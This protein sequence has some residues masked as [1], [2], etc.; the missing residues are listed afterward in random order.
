[1]LF[2]TALEQR[3]IVVSITQ[4]WPIAYSIFFAYKL[5]K[6]SK[7]PVTISLSSFFITQSI[8][9]LMLIV[10]IFTVNTSVS[11]P[12]YILGYYLYFFSFA[13]LIIFSWIILNVDKKDS[14]KSNFV[15]IIFYS[16]TCGCIIGVGILTSGIQYG[17]NTGW[18]PIFSLGFA[19]ISW[20][21]IGLVYFIP[22]IIIV[23]KL[24]RTFKTSPIK[25]RINLLVISLLMGISL[26]AF[27]ILYNYW[28][29]NGYYRGIHTFIALPFA[30]ISAYI[31]YRSLGK[32]LSK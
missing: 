8:A 26:A 29:D 17:L 15:L 9:L 32:G 11:Y 28:I 6:R 16:L 27:P 23:F 24:L 2:L 3:I 21:Y 7:N 30:T 12:I 31:S 19:I 1:M 14:Y 5:L 22:E 4:C 10:S 13:F 25:K 20:L 18:I